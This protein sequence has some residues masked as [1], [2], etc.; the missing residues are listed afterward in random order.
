[1]GLS[2][3]QNLPSPQTYRSDKK[4]ANLVLLNVPLPRIGDELPGVVVLSVGIVKLT[5]LT[6]TKGDT[7]ADKR[8]GILCFSVSCWFRSLLAAVACF[9]PPEEKEQSERANSVGKKQAVSSSK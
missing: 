3:C 5:G 4:Q 1:M 7:R 2:F 8:V 9:P 6:Q